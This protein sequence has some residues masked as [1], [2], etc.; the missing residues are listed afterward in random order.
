MYCFLVR[1][2]RILPMWTT[3]IARWVG[4]MYAAETAV[5]HT[6]A[7]RTAEGRMKNHRTSTTAHSTCSAD[8]IWHH[9][10]GLAWC[11]DC[12]I[13]MRGVY[14]HEFWSRDV[15]TR[16]VQSPVLRLAIILRGLDKESVGLCLN[17]FSFHCWLFYRDITTMNDCWVLLI[18]KC[19]W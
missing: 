2:L 10:L 9:A 11:E 19:T 8:K 16:Y 1:K 15:S 17:N 5:V 13:V 14:W 12:S 18:Q 3:T 4:G 7:I 6:W